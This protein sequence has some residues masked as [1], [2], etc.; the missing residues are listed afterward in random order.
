LTSRSTKA[1]VLLLAPPRG[2]RGRGG[3]FSSS[4]SH[5]DQQQQQPQQQQGTTEFDCQNGQGSKQNVQCCGGTIYSIT[6]A[7]ET[8]GVNI[9]WYSLKAT[10]IIHHPG[11]GLGRSRHQVPGA[12]HAC[13]TVVSCLS[14][15][16]PAVPSAFDVFH[17]TDGLVVAHCGSG[18]YVV[19]WRKDNAPTLNLLAAAVA[20]NL[21][22]KTVVL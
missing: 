10:V 6:W 16:D 12:K 15:P 14:L 22:M 11:H 21:L 13:S 8:M 2:G 19:R 18:V 17:V 3:S 7:L 5:P 1:A 20:T 4:S 9:P